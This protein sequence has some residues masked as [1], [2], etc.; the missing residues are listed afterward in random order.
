MRDRFVAAETVCPLIPPPVFGKVRFFCNN[1]LDKVVP[2]PIEFVT[3][4]VNWS[5]PNPDICKLIVVTCTACV[6]V[7]CC[8]INW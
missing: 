4:T 8:A 7:N 6:S 5:V 3:Q 2:G 1:T